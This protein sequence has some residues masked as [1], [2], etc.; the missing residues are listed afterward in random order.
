MNQGTPAC[1]RRVGI[2]T[3]TSNKK[4]DQAIVLPKGIL[5]FYFADELAAALMEK[6]EREVSN[7]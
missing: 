4:P 3:V 5:G 6:K 7:G 1:L 2:T